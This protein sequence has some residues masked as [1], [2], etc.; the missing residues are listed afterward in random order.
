MSNVPAADQKNTPQGSALTDSPVIVSRPLLKLKLLDSLRNN[1]FIQL[2]FLLNTTFN[3]WDNSDVQTVVNL[4][5]HYAVQVAPITLIKEIVEDFIN[6]EPKNNSTNNLNTDNLHLSINYQDSNGNT[7]L[8][9]AALQGRTDVV[10]YLLS[11]PNINDCVKNNANLQPFQLC[12]NANLVQIMQIKRSTYIVE[13][14]QNLRLAFNN[15]DFETLGVLLTKPR[16]LALLDIN[17]MDPQT[18][19]TVLHEFVKKKDVQMCQWLLQH[20]A[21]P[22]KRDRNGRLPIELLKNVSEKDATN[23]K[24]EEN[25]VNSVD[26]E[27]R[28]LLT[29]AINNQS[30]IDSTV[31]INITKQ[32][33]TLK[34][35]LQKWTNFAQGYKLRWFVLSTDGILSYYIDEADTRNACRGSLNVSTCVLHLDSSENLKFEITGG[36]NGSVNWHL[37]GNHP[38]ETSKWVWAIQGAI[39]FAKDREKAEYNLRNNV[40]NSP[41]INNDISSPVMR[42]KSSHSISNGNNLSIGPLSSVVD[43]DGNAN[44][45]NDSSIFVNSPINSSQNAIQKSRSSSLAANNFPIDDN[46]TIPRSP[47]AEAGQFSHILDDTQSI[48]TGKSKFKKVYVLNGEDVVSEK[49]N[50]D[51]YDD[52]NDNESIVFTSNETKEEHFKEKTSKE[53]QKLQILQRTISMQLALLSDLLRDNKT[54]S[55]LS[56][57]IENSLATISTCFKDLNNLV[58]ER[59]QVLMNLIAKQ[60]DVN[61]VW[62]QSV[63]ELEEELNEKSEKLGKLENERRNLKKVFIKS[64]I[65][66]ISSL[67]NL[68]EY[69]NLSKVSSSTSLIS[70]TDEN[71]NAKNAFDEVAKFIENTKDEEE[72]D[73]MDLDEFFDAEDALSFDEVQEYTG[74][75]LPREE[76]K[77][78][79][80]S[81]LLTVDTSITENNK[82]DNLIKENN[83]VPQ[84]DGHQELT[85][86]KPALE[87]HYSE[88]IY[89]RLNPTN[90]LQK[91]KEQ[92][93]IEDQSFTGYEDGIRQR[94]ELDADNRPKVSLW[95]VLKSMVGKDITKIALP[96]TFNEPTSLLQR[97]TEDLEYSELL[98]KAASFDDST[99]RMLYVSIFSLAAYSSTPKRVAKPFNPL[100]GETFEY[101]RPDK[102]FRFMAEQVSHHPPITAFW[103]ESPRWEY[104]GESHVTSNFNGRAFHFNHMGMWHIKIRPDASEQEELYTWMKPENVLVGILTGSPEIDCAGD[105]KI[106][107]HQTGDYC[108]LHYKARGWRASD[109]YEV[110]GEVFN[111]LGEKKWIFG[112]HWNDSIFAKRVLSPSDNSTVE[113]NNNL[114][115]TENDIESVFAPKTDGSKFLVW[116]CKRRPEGPF[117]LTSFAITLNAPQP[118][119][120][121]W[122]APTDTRL[123]PDQRA[124]EDGSYD[125][126]ADE[127]FRL[128]TKQRAVRKEREENDIKYVPKWFAKEIHPA[129]NHQYWKMVNGYWKHRKQHKF[130]DCPDLF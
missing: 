76:I 79:T 71:P 57:T 33:P 39:R 63:K 88:E 54:S 49:S 107:N 81:T 3:P 126:A 61:N 69:N 29:N 9:L 127:K 115:D 2:K 91:A 56:K 36:N 53:N 40:M 114:S 4:L 102:H 20:N 32:S 130:D 67:E 15:R 110:R 120:I 84:L 103:T 19:D 30:V 96:V 90:E 92:E 78:Q 18:G 23:T 28:N 99:L 125:V 112:G 94:L 124:M 68:N 38:I 21:D 58:R 41:I 62:I 98:D 24:N 83:E 42:S 108:I 77:L 22:F 75:D 10:T 74:S 7:P 117:N 122:L 95:S 14:A 64:K 73:E 35:Y 116:K 109:A 11:N 82:V 93:F 86:V 37:K 27:L 111:I 119:L 16:N 5:L 66:E 128:E 44:E 87:T 129:T 121:P 46:L 50:E 113:V 12:K 59:D 60:N 47:I 97:V 43:K 26:L 106:M 123:R 17:G 89:Q 34:G 55:E 1:D 31:N 101:C 105:V 13:I 72:E 70:G 65:N 25:K 85:Q 51:N 8:H 118:H 80:D 45:I 48:M 52:D 6:K 100:L 104:W